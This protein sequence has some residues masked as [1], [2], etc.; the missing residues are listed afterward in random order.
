[1]GSFVALCFIMSQAFA[2]NTVYDT[3]TGI[4]TIPTVEI[5]GKIEFLNVQ[6]GLNEDGT[7]SVLKADLPA[8]NNTANC[9]SFQAGTNYCIDGTFPTCDTTGVSV[10]EIKVG[11]SYDEI[12]NLLGCHGVLTTSN[13]DVALYAWGEEAFF[14][15][16]IIFKNGTV[17]SISR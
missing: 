1:M 12:V 2:E 11:M 5:N 10:S 13:G 8:D 6:L 3:D 15:R 7:F 9:S 14:D 17:D 4:A 16:A